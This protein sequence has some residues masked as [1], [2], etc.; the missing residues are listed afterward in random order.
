MVCMRV[1]GALDN[2]NDIITHSNKP[3]LVLKVVF[4]SS[5]TN[6]NMKIPIY[7]VNLGEDFGI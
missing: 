6:L 3:S 7:E 4:H 2:P 5:H 1:A